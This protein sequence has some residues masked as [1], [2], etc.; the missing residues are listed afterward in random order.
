[1][2]SKVKRLNRPRTDH[3]GPNGEYRTISNLSLTSAL[4]GSG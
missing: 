1:M 3:E 4:D 2:Y